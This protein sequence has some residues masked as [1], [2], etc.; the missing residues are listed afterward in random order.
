[1]GLAQYNRDQ[2][3]AN[4]IIDVM[5]DFGAHDR[6]GAVSAPTIFRAC[7]AGISISEGNDFT[8]PRVADM[9]GLLAGY[10]ALTSYREDSGIG[11]LALYAIAVENLR[12]MRDVV[13]GVY[14]I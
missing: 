7:I 13:R 3:I 9:I 11:E 10:G 5:L 14:P 4:R 6:D 2:R 8:K 1:M 12:G